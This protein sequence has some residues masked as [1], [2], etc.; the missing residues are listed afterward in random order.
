MVRIEQGALKSIEAVAEDYWNM[1]NPYS[2][3]MG[4][5]HN[6]S[7]ITRITNKRN[8]HQEIGNVAHAD[9][10][11]AL[12]NDLGM[13]LKQIIL[14]RPEDT[15][16]LINRMD[17]L[18]LALGIP[19]GSTDPTSLGYEILHE[20]FDYKGW[21]SSVKSKELLNW[22]GVNVCPYCNMTPVWVHSDGER[23]LAVVSYDHF[24]DKATYPYL[25]LSFYN[26]IPACSHCNETYKNQRTFT[27]AT[28]FHPYLDHYNDVNTFDHDYVNDAT[29]YSITLQHTDA[30]SPV[31]NFDLGLVSRVNL[32]NEKRYAKLIH[33]ASQRYPDSVKKEMI[34]VWG[35]TNLAEV[36]QHI[37]QEEEIPFRTSEILNRTFGKMQRDFAL[38]GKIFSRNN[39]LL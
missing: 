2:Q 27:T 35:L 37:C 4:R 14:V 39:P 17:E 21:R 1:L 20:V 32:P 24:Y 7:L 3:A 30:R 28:H 13:L 15:A 23:R 34:D 19:Q 16:E 6:N 9:F 22:L 33:R 11:T 12:L 38:K 25:C 10:Y 8:R 18:H 31:F 5:Y 29:P 36:E 26:L